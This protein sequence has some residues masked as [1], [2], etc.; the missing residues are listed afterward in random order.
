MKV[1]LCVFICLCHVQ[2]LFSLV[3]H[4]SSGALVPEETPE[5]EAARQ[6]HLSA[7]AA[8]AA[9]EDEEERDI[10]INGGVNGGQNNFFFVQPLLK[11]KLKKFSKQHKAGKCD[12]N[13]RQ[14][15]SIYNKNNY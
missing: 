14:I 7:L 9:E 12:C 15:G 2:S 11:R 10:I 1:A 13:V 6:F 5:V 4:H 3:L 8:A